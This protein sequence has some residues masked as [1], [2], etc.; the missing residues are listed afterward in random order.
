MARIRQRVTT[1][2]ARRPDMLIIRSA[3]RF[4]TVF[5]VAPPVVLL[6]EMRTINESL[7][8]PRSHAVESRPRSLD[9]QRTH[10]R[11]G[12]P[13]FRTCF[14]LAASTAIA[15]LAIRSVNRPKIA[16]RYLPAM[17]TAAS[18]PLS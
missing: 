12:L 2:A 5:P 18:P 4:G 1:P 16:P 15:I 8:V 13:R 9:E 11:I 17:A 10:L 7:Q 3:C 6:R 14:L